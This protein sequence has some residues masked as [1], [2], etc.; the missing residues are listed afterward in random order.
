MY[1]EQQRSDQLCAVHAINAVLQAPI[2]TE[3]DLAEVAQELDREERSMGRRSAENVSLDGFFSIQVIIRALHSQGITLEYLDQSQFLSGQSDPTN[4][5]SL[6]F[7]LHSHWQ[8]YRKVA[9]V[10]LDLNSLNPLPGPVV[11]SSFALAS[12]IEAMIGSGYTVF[13]A[14]GS[15]RKYR[16]EE[17]GRQ[18]WQFWIPMSRLLHVRREGYDEEAEIRK[19]L[20]AS[21]RDALQ[22][23]SHTSSAVP[24]SSPP[25]DPELA[26]A[27]AL[28]LTANLPPL[29]PEPLTNPSSIPLKVKFPDG[30]SH[31]RR[32][33]PSDTVSSV[34][35]WVQWETKT[36]VK[37]I[38]G[39]PPMC[40][41]MQKRVIDCGTAILMA[42]R[43]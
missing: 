22:S 15:F 6:I 38:C 31:I 24:D 1:W 14:T 12:N 20:E 37:I 18:K 27:I 36:E 23:I 33:L 21:R 41:D 4:A 16:K 19:A 26:E 13:L 9:E 43:R 40:L 30:K 35:L 3:V 25:I 10:W 5:T 29:P 7:N 42:V 34:A 17:F 32:F 11:I 2:Y 39:Y 28:S 8:T